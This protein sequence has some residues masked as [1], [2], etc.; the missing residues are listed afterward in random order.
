MA[1]GGVNSS[2]FGAQNA[3]YGVLISIGPGTASY[4]VA[5][6]GRTAGSGLEWMFLDNWSA[7]AEYMYYSLN[8]VFL[9]VGST[10]HQRTIYGNGLV[11]GDITD[12]ANFFSRTNFNGNIVRAGVNY[13]FNL[14][15]TPVVT[16]Y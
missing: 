16:K 13:H 10:I 14:P 4:S 5:N 15:A 2:F 9:Y 7:K 1:Y 6:L 12:L 8:P 11:P 3:S